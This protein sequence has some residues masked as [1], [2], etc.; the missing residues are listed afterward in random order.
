MNVILWILTTS[1]SHKYVSREEMWCNISQKYTPG[2]FLY[3]GSDVDISL[4]K[5][6]E[7]Y[8]LQITFVDLLLDTEEE[9]HFKPLN[10][11]KSQTSIPIRK[12]RS[13]HRK[14]QLLEQSLR[15]KISHNVKGEILFSRIYDD[16]HLY[17]KCKIYNISRDF[18][19]HMRDIQE[20]VYDGFPVTTITHIG[21]TNSYFMQSKFWSLISYHNASILK[22]YG[23]LN[24]V[25]NTTIRYI[26][27]GSDM[28][29]GKTYYTKKAHPPKFTHRLA[30]RPTIISTCYL[31]F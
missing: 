14:I 7:P 24:G 13:K 28:L 27:F 2:H 10:F 5:L 18:N 11:E 12:E 31:P 4:L 26:S 23:L 16:Y 15:H 8:E 3:L 9:H 1:L 29:S 30:G 20:F 19:F 6:I 21:V 17:I 25:L 22:N